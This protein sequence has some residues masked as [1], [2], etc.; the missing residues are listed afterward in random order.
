MS[1][2]NPNRRPQPLREPRGTLDFVESMISHP[3][4]LTKSTKPSLAN[5][6]VKRPFTK[7]TL[8]ISQ[9]KMVRNDNTGS[10]R[11]EGK[12]NQLKSSAKQNGFNMSTK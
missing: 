12:S 3:S 11:V 1:G 6:L 10:S 9:P 2:R 8:S 5:S 7:P 4:R